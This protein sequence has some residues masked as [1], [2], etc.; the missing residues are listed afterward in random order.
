VNIADFNVIRDHFQQNVTGRSMGDLD[1]DGFVDWT[2]FRQ[3][4][5]FREAAVA[6]GQAVP[7]PTAAALA[8]ACI[9]SLGAISRSRRRRA[10]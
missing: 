1:A 7:E 6:S 4:K 2:D 10:A 8:L 3:W 9:A 5:Q